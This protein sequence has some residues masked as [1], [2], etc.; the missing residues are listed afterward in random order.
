LECCPEALRAL[1][2][3]KKLPSAMGESSTTGSEEGR[4]HSR[5]R[6]PHH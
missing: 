2:M 4:V 3:W 5:G 1:P 6:E